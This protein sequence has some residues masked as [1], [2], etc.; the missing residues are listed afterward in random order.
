MVRRA[1]L[2]TRSIEAGFLPLDQP[3]AKVHISNEAHMTW[4]IEGVA[5]A[6]RC[7]GHEDDEA[8]EDQ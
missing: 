8:R 4:A 7:P 5:A 3:A 2:A 1:I 6:R